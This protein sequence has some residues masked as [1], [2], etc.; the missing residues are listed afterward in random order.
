MVCRECG[1]SAP[2]RAVFC[3]RCGARLPDRL[4][5]RAATSQHR[6]T[7]RWLAGAVALVAG[8]AV[9]GA[10]VVGHAPDDG[11]AVQESD[12]GQVVLPNTVPT[13]PATSPPASPSEPSRPVE[14][15]VTP[16]DCDRSEPR[17]LSCP[18]WT[19]Q[20]PG[21]FGQPVLTGREVLVGTS[22]GLVALRPDTGGLLWAVSVG[23]QVR[24]PPA[25]DAAAVYVADHLGRVSALARGSGDR[26]WQTDVGSVRSGPV[27]AGDTVVLAGLDQLVGLDAAT[28]DRRWT[29][30]ISGIP[31]PPTVGADTVY[32][33]DGDGTIRALDPATGDVRWQHTVRAWSTALADQGQVLMVSGFGQPLRGLDP[34]TGQQQWKSD[35]YP[36]WTLPTAEG[37]PSVLYARADGRIHAV[38]PADGSHRTVADQTAGQLLVGDGGTLHVVYPAGRLVT[39][40]SAGEALADQASDD[41]L[42][43]VTVGTVGASGWLVA[44]DG[45]GMRLVAWPAPTPVP[46]DALAELPAG[47]PCPVTPTTEQPYLT[48]AAGRHVE[49]GGL[50]TTDEPGEVTLV[51]D[52][53]PVDRPLVIRGLQLD[54]LGAMAFRLGLDQPPRTALTLAN[55]G[56]RGAPGWPAHYGL[57]ASV[58]GPGCWAYLVTTADGDTDQ[59]VVAIGQEVWA[60][61]PAINRHAPA[62]LR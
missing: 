48:V 62:D 18:T 7:A 8:F 21:G 35:L 29:V 26:R 58:S 3:G 49:I 50:G 19:A 23:G 46:P 20:S 52:P 39:L 10:A 32:V 4:P 51:V 53:E 28:G 44:V 41:G 38:D 9:A 13:A 22:T 61:L 16:P 54:G 55:D 27:V 25:Y 43:W 30:G 57:V 1:A 37:K 59:I 34:V 60:D 42:Q 40:N 5:D 14:V 36:E 2:A 33:G 15:T 6:R 47:Q 17:Q 24:H 56:L 31:S 11:G 12:R 45:S